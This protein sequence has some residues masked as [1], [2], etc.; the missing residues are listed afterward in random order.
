MRDRV[1]SHAPPS[2]RD[3]ELQGHLPLPEP[4]AREEGGVVGDPVQ[5]EAQVW[6]PATCTPCAPSHGT[7]EVLAGS[8]KVYPSKAGGGARAGFEALT[9][10]RQSAATQGPPANRHPSRMTLG[11]QCRDVFPH[12]GGDPIRW[13]AFVAV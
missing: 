1:G 10:H 5:H 9:C 6:R 2:H 4:P 11:F 13:A 3:E 7:P 12:A 8:C